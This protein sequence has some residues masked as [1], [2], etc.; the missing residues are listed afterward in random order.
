MLKHSPRPLLFVMDR[1][2]FSLS[3]LG[4]GRE[5][6]QSRRNLAGTSQQLPSVTVTA[7]GPGAGLSVREKSETTID[8]DVAVCR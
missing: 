8:R 1:M 2:A 4:S 7:S 5:T 6:P 3:N